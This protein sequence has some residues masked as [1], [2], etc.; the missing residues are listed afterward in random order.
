PT[1][2]LLREYDGDLPVHHVDAYRLT[3][4]VELEDLGLDE[5]LAADAV[6]FVEWADKVAAVLPESWL[7]LVL[8]ICDDDTREV[9][10]RPHGPA[11][12]ARAEEL[13]T[14]LA[15]FT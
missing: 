4:P 10:V 2:M 5:V 3:G 13:Q 7:E 6:A 12:A 1:F 14:A 11:W 8:R 9:D 15:S